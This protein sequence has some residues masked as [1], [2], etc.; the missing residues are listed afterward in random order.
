M[1][2][3][4]KW[5]SWD[6][7][8]FVSLSLLSSPWCTA[9]DKPSP[10]RSYHGEVKRNLQVVFWTWH[11]CLQQNHRMNPKWLVLDCHWQQPLPCQTWYHLQTLW[12][13]WVRDCWVPSQCWLLQLSVLIFFHVLWYQFAWVSLSILLHGNEQSRKF[14]KGFGFASSDR[15]GYGT[16]WK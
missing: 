8:G 4:Q 11:Y 10:S 7:V 9:V 2:A 13:H 16:M 12:A 6:V 14:W 1:R 3:S 5:R 15:L